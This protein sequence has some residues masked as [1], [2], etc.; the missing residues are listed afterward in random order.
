[1]EWAGDDKIYDP[2]AVE[3]ALKN[4]DELQQK[5]SL[6]E[7]YNCFIECYNIYFVFLSIDQKGI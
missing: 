6:A 2:F 7:R 4:D 5:L 1:M 3:L